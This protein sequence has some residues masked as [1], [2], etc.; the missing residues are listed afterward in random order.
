MVTLNIVNLIIKIFVFIK[1]SYLLILTSFY[2]ETYPLHL[3][4]WWIYYLIFDVW[5]L[6]SFKLTKGEV[7]SK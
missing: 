3:L 2:P 7:D 5:L 1:I 6:M 4:N